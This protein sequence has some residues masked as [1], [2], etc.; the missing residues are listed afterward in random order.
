MTEIGQD[1][2]IFFLNT[3]T[4]IFDIKDKFEYR[5]KL[6][7]DKF[8]CSLKFN[9]QYWES[10]EK[11]E[12]KL[13]KEDVARIVIKELMIHVPEKFKQVDK[14]L[15]NT[16]A[17]ESEKDIQANLAGEGNSC[18]S[19]SKKDI[20]ASP[21]GEKMLTKYEIAKIGKNLN[22]IIFLNTYTNRFD[23]KDKLQYEF[24]SSNNKFIYSLKFKDQ[25]W[26]SVEKQNKKQAKE[27][28]ARIA[29]N[30]LITQDPEKCERIY[31]LLRTAKPNGKASLRYQN[32]LKQQKK[33]WQALSFQK[34][35]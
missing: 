5:Y 33:K 21:V 1:N 30:Y 13:A 31:G 3:Y 20:E 14:L 32:K 10:S 4:R 27:D 24:R 9:N 7:N 28:V 16:E 26:E 11:P 2:P 34:N 25:Y 15:R 18:S 8:I 17:N 19:E 23:I 6:C 29:V 12:K 22:P 35:S